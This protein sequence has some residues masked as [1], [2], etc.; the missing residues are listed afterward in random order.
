MNP[1]YLHPNIPPT[2][3]ISQ[4]RQQLPN[5]NTVLYFSP[6][7]PFS[8]RS[9]A[10]E[11][12]ENALFYLSA[13]RFDVFG[14]FSSHMSRKPAILAESARRI[15]ATFKEKPEV[16]IK[17]LGAGYGES[18]AILLSE[19]KNRHPQ[20]YQ[21]LK[22]YASD[23]YQPVLAAMQRSETLQPF[24]A[25][26]KLVASHEDLLGKLPCHKKADYVR[27][28]YTLTDLPEDLI[29]KENG[30]FFVA[31]V[32]GYIS[33]TDDF[34]TDQGTRVPAERIAEL[35][36]EG[37][38]QEII[39]LGL[40]IRAIQPRVGYEVEYHPIDY[41][42]YTEGWLVKSILEEITAGIE[43]TH[44]RMGLNA[45]RAVEKVVVSHLVAETGSTM[46]VFD[47][48][49]SEVLANM[50]APYTGL[51]FTSVNSVN[52]P[53]IKAYLKAKN[54]P[55]SIQFEDWKQYLNQAEPYIYLSH[56]S[57]WLKGS[58]DEVRAFFGRPLPE[59][60]VSRIVAFLEKTKHVA[61]MVL[62]AER[63][64]H[65]FVKLLKAEG[66]SKEEIDLLFSSRNFPE[67]VKS[68]SR[69][70][71]GLYQVVTLRRA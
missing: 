17:E 51:E 50:P 5:G 36:E 67:P 30:Q 52:L 40:D 26:G 37:K 44:L 58:P 32:R 15:A 66:F 21:N 20:L 54:V 34:T 70:F 59:S 62:Y 28:S 53:F 71:Y 61:D 8:H 7:L 6:F 39:D 18:M 42:R 48:W 1:V 56:F 24:L 4:I 10:R 63:E 12:I 64:S 57:K 19:I 27:I 46:E 2:G 31:K 13:Q 14:C 47:L 68:Q 69:G 35:L 49:T 3:R 60:T 41:S 9:N 23:G 55:V 25:E 16:V 22:A 45:A 11:L 43:S 33:D 65:P 29:K 38:I